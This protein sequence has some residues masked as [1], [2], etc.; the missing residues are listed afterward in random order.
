MISVLEATLRLRERCNAP[1]FTMEEAYDI[2]ASPADHIAEVDDSRSSL[3]APRP[4][5]QS[6]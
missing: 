2:I 5:P 4:A 6:S 1:N 3:L